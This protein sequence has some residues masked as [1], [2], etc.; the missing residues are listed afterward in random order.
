MTKESNKI[1]RRGFFPQILGLLLVPFVKTRAQQV[2]D[3][4]AYKTFIKKDGTV[5][6]IKSSHL[7]NVK[8]VKKKVSN[9][10]LFKW[11]NNN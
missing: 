10:T 5:V 7:N 2:E 9:K 4:S 6:K 8:I 11:L 3:I 1:S